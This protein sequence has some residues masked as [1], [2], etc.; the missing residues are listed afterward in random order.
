MSQFGWI[1][2]DTFSDLLIL[3]QNEQLHLTEITGSKSCKLLYR[4]TRDGFKNLAFYSK[5]EN[6]Q[7]LV[8]I[9]RNDSNYVFGGFISR[10]WKRGALWIGDENAFIFSLRRNGETKKDKFLIQSNGNMAFDTHPHY[11]FSHG[12]DIHITNS[13]NTKVG[14][15]CDLGAHFQLPEGMKY[16]TDNARDFLAGNSKEWLATEVE[17]YEIKTIIPLE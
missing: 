17:V 2:T 10:A 16:N 14:S 4:A 15:R 3:N 9:I 5:C 12:F 6:K 8:S 11:L 7:N 13:P 1:S